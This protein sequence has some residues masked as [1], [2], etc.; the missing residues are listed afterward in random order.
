MI[1]DT[2]AIVAYMFGEPQT[3]AIAEILVDDPGPL[4]SAGTALELSIVVDGRRNPMLSRR[5][6]EARREFGIGISPVTATHVDIARQAYRDFG[7][8]SGHPAQLNFGDCF[9]YALAS[10]RNEPLLYVGDDFSH[11]DLRSALD[12]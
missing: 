8:G 6:D 10:E 2:S 1:V 12:G 11:T 5:M 3:Q 4:M 9:A 7:K